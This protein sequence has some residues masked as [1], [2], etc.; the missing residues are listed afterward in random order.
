LEF[1]NAVFERIAHLKIGILINEKNR[2]KIVLLINQ[3]HGKAQKM[4][5][6]K[7]QEEISG[8]AAEVVMLSAIMM[9]IE[10]NFNKALSESLNRY[11]KIKTDDLI[12]ETKN[13]TCPDIFV[14]LPNQKPIQQK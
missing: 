2:K 13:N 5:N 4:L 10:D 9:A 3:I 7:S 12:K 6:K 11:L 1:G 8:L 14:K